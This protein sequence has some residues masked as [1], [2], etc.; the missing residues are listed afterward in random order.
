MAVAKWDIKVHFD[1][2][3]TFGNAIVLDHERHESNK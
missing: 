1:G 3:D 2:K